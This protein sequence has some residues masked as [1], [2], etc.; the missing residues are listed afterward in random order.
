ML[1]WGP[2]Y[3]CNL[4]QGNTWPLKVVAQWFWKSSGVCEIVARTTSLVVLGQIRTAVRIR[5]LHL[6]LWIMVV[7]N[8]FPRVD[9]QVVA[10]NRRGKQTLV[11]AKIHQCNRQ[12]VQNQEAS[13]GRFRGQGLRVV[14][15]ESQEKQRSYR[16]LVNGEGLCSC[17]VLVSRQGWL[18]VSPKKSDALIRF[19]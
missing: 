5:E 6:V 14:A 1:C 15:C 12:R 10:C 17:R 4:Y 13:R 18:L 2:S 7:T 11:V 3:E 9:Y 19:C 16:G 8:L